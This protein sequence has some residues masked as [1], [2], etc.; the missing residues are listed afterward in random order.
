M[1]DRVVAIRR[2]LVVCVALLALTGLTI[3]LAHL[4]LG[5]WNSAVAM[6]IAIIKAVLIALFFMHLRGSPA[7]TRLV[8]L[9]ALLW[10]GILLVGTM[11]DLLT[12]GWLPIPGK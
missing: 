4:N 12:R 9:A 11:D 3:G 7:V 2:Y 10:L 6:A 8:A 1:P 5:G